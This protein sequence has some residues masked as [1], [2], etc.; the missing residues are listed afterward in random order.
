MISKRFIIQCESIASRILNFVTNF[1]REEN[2][3]FSTFL[4][5]FHL[6]Q[7]VI[8][9]TV[10]KKNREMIVDRN[11]RIQQ[12]VISMHFKSHLKPCQVWHRFPCCFY[13]QANIFPA[14]VH[15]GGRKLF[16]KIWRWLLLSRMYSKL[17]LKWAYTL[18]RYRISQNF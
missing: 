12:Q 8:S 10:Y 3:V 6:Q 17:T 13:K 1:N 2:W 16:H 9:L 7:H 4:H 15:L 18:L 14:H 11:W 5:L